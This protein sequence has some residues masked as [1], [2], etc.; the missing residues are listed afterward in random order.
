MTL[1]WNDR[2]G[3]DEPFPVSHPLNKG[4]LITFAPQQPAMSAADEADEC[5]AFEQMSYGRK[6]G[7][8]LHGGRHIKC[9]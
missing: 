3:T 2:R 6:H 4:G 9:K 1:R 7:G 8:G 5:R